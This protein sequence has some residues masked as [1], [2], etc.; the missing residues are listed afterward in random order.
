MNTTRSHGFRPEIVGHRG[1]AGLEPENTLPSFRRAMELGV[2]WVELDV[3]LTTDG[4]PVLLHDVLLDRTTDA[5]GPVSA[6]TLE[7]LRG[8]RSGGHPIPTLSEA[9]DALGPATRCLVE[10][11][12]DDAREAEQV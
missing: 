2:E 7:A 6:I 5:T 10:L 1:A 11:K 4:W 3:R 8:V 12:R 9:L